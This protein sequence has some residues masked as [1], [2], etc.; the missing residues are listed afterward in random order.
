MS[1]TFCATPVWAA[2]RSVE[3]VT[4]YPFLQEDLYS[5]SQPSEYTWLRLFVLNFFSCQFQRID[6][7]F[8]F[9]TLTF[10]EIL[11]TISALFLMDTGKELWL[12]QGWWPEREKSLDCEH[13]SNSE[14]EEPAQN[15]DN[16]RGSATVRWQAERRAA[17]QTVLDY[18]K[19]KY[20]RKS[21]QAYL[22]WAG[23]E[24]IQFTNLF[25]D[26]KDR[27]DVAEMNILVSML[28]FVAEYKRD[29]P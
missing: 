28:F 7:I 3:A 2:C 13:S 6:K 26:W 4:A 14:D 19:S 9:S 12:W 29:C 23:L 18:W 24:P 21:V 5:A 15:P 17:M 8:H 16:D 1:G 11:L 27:D 10:I 25:P 22:V 20:P